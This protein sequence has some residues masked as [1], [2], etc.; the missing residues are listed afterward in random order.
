MSE[1]DYYPAGAY[2][3]P[4]APYN[5]PVIPE[6][7]FDITVSQS[8]SKEITVWT[9]DYCTEYDD[10]DGNTYVNT[11]DTDWNKVFEENNYHTPLQLIQLLGEVLQKDLDNGVVFKNPRF[12][13]E[14]IH[15]CQGWSDDETVITE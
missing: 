7:E 1:A 6:R 13:H 8:L 5:Q 11:E 10:E 12:T 3:D 4:D 9:D 14:L 2:N 15:E